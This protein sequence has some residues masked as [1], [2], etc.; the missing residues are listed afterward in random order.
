MQQIWISFVESCPYVV[1]YWELILSVRV[2]GKQS[3][4]T[5]AVFD[6]TSLVQ[7]YVVGSFKS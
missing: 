4:C 2:L 5:A 1:S 7:L 3:S 6:L